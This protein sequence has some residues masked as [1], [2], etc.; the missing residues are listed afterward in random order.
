[1]DWALALKLNL[2]TELL[3]QPI[4][5]SALD[6]SLLFCVTH[7]TEKVLVMIGDHETT[8]SFHVFSAPQRSLVLGLPW[9][10]EHNPHIDW[11]TEKVLS[12]AEGCIRDCFKSWHDSGGPKE[13]NTVSVSHATDLVIPDLTSVPT[14]ERYSAKTRPLCFPLI[15]LTTAPLTSSRG[16]PSQRGRL[17]SIFCPEKEAMNEYIEASLKSGL[18]RPRLERGSFLCERRMGHSD[19]ALTIVLL[20]TLR[21]K[22]ATPSLSCRHPSTNSSRLKS[23]PS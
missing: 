7:K 12:W 18:I 9:L 10:K 5:A 6:G 14:W 8:T 19:H 1:M 3:S 15:G 17:Y 22:T 13:I 16:P 23:S 20:M 11:N 2:K 21:L 4:E